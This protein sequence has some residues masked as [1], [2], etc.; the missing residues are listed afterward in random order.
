MQDTAGG[1]AHE[2]GTQGI[3]CANP[4]QTLKYVKGAFSKF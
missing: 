2:G 3:S 4:E 1:S